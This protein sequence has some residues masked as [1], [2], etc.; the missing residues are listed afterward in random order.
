MLKQC[1]HLFFAALLLSSLL[2]AQE[3]EVKDAGKFS[4]SING[5]EFQNMI[6]Y[7]KSEGL[8]TI[9]TGDESFT[10]TINWRGVNFPAEIKPGTKKLPV[11]DNSVT[12]SY[13]D[14]KMEMPFIISGGN[15]TVT[16]S[17]GKMLK[18][19]LEFTA[20]GGGIPKEMG[21]TE[22]KL[23]KGKFEIDLTK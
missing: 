9:A 17:D 20:A 19:T 5:K 14:N 4:G 1:I 3:V 11:N 12:V 2:L 7:G 13:L 10:L 6:R 23:T 22:T 15:L 18:G 8:F 16:E 21:G